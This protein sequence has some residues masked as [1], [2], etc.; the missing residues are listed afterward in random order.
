[1]VLQPSIVEN[2]DGARKQVVIPAEAG[3][4]KNKKIFY[5]RLDSCFRRNDERIER[6]FIN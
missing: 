4:Q 1:L 6:L 3:I 5:N 2:H